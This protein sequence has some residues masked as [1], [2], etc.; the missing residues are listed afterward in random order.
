MK[1]FHGRLDGR[2]L[3]GLLLPVL[4][5][6]AATGCGSDDSSDSAEANDVD[7][8]F[9]AEMVPHHES[10]IDMAKLAQ[11]RAQ[12]EQIKTLSNN[13][14][15]SQSAEIK[16]LQ[17][18]NDRVGSSSEAMQQDSG[19]HRGAGGSETLGLSAQQMGMDH[20]LARLR[21]AQ[22]F[23]REFIDMMVPHHQGA[24]R[25][26]RVELAKGQ[27]PQLKTLARQI[28]SA[29]TQEIEQMNVWRKDWYGKVSPAGG[30]PNANEDAAQQGEQEM[31][32]DSGEHGAGHGG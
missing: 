11:A 20:D 6:V 1:R 4:I 10:A 23:D 24:I 32:G 18:G 27:D 28:I 19:M 26:A 22:P 16:Q 13:I 30:V 14:I 17:D 31:P 9:A 15:R 2:R 7:R 8:A 21:S 5:A 3:A 29:Q 25:M 12:H